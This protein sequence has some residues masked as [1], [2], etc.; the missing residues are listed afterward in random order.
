M[1]RPSLSYLRSTIVVFLGVFFGTLAGLTASVGSAFSTPLVRYLLGAR[2]A[3]ASALAATFF[4]SLTALTTYG[5]HHKVSW[6]AGVALAVAQIVGVAFAE[7]RAASLHGGSGLRIFWSVVGIGAGLSM[8]GYSARIAGLSTVPLPWSV[9]HSAIGALVW[10]FVVGAVAGGISQIMELGG[11]L[12]VPACLLL[13]RLDPEMAM[14]TALVG[15]IAVSLSG[16]LIY[17]RAG[18]VDRDAGAQMSL[19][20]LF[21]GLVGA[22]FAMRVSPS[23]LVTI[24]GIVLAL[25]AVGRFM[26]ASGRNRPV[27]AGSASG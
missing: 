12:V 8:V 13:L 7:R 17:L 2:P 15:L 24:Y 23:M 21:G 10:V 14:G 22:Y 27:E 25:V 18:E 19:G 6:G 20:A 9:V 16:L 3:R 26:S 4:A 1:S 11:V 5:H